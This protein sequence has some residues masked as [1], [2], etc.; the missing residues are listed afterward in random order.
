MKKP[1]PCSVQKPETLVSTVNTKHNVSTN[2]KKP[3]TVLA[4]AISNQTVQT[5]T[6][7]TTIAK[8]SKVPAVPISST[9]RTEAKNPILRRR[10]MVLSTPIRITIVNSRGRLLGSRIVDR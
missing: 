4:L 8:S 10:T 1:S 7:T 2:K 3:T 5:T 9:T 6:T